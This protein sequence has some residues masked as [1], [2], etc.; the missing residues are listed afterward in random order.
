MGVAQV[1]RDDAYVLREVTN[2][3]AQLRAIADGAPTPKREGPPLPPASV[4]AKR[5]R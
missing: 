4:D 5:G 1:Y 3:A 2:L